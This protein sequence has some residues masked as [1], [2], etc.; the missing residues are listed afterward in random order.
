MVRHVESIIQRNCVKWF[1]LQY[2]E[3]RMLLFS[4]PNGGY[5][6]AAEAR[7]MKAEGIVAGVSDLILMYPSKGYHALCIEMKTES[8]QSKQTENQKE[9]QEAVE[10]RGYKYVVCRSFNE[11]YSEVSGYINA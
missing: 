10:Q 8:R 7:I 6:N 4:V 9:W 1:R 5:R 11:F 2:P 3:L